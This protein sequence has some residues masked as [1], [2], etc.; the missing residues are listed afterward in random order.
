M[1]KGTSTMFGYGLH[2]MIWGIAIGLIVF[3]FLLAVYFRVW[4]AEGWHPEMILG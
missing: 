2:H 3:A 4:G 1:K